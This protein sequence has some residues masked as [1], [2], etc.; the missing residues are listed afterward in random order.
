MAIPH[1]VGYGG[2]IQPD[3][4]FVPLV[5][6]FALPSLAMEITMNEVA[7]MEIEVDGP[8]EAISVNAT[9]VDGIAVEMEGPGEAISVEATVLAESTE[10]S[11]LASI[12]G[13][14]T[15]CPV[16]EGENV[17]LANAAGAESPQ[18][19]RCVCCSCCNRVGC[20][21]PTC[22]AAS[23]A[24]VPVLSA[25]PNAWVPAACRGSASIARASCLPTQPWC[26]VRASCST[27]RLVCIV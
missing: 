26:V 5:L 6:T 1:G 24:W 11:N 3:Q 25:V 17:S 9:S 21:P 18:T 27:C 10:E 23:D 15:A 22:T 13:A 20:P 8:G 14:P 2:Q 7:A 19:D 12:D 16:D 4:C